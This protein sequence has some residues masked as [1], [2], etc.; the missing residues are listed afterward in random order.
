MNKFNIVQR[1]VEQFKYTFCLPLERIFY[2]E[3]AEEFLPSLFK[4]SF[5]CLYIMGLSAKVWGTEQNQH[6]HMI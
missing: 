3:K 6:C 4:K 2:L 5:C 1:P